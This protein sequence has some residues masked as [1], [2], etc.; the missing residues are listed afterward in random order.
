MVKLPQNL[1]YKRFGRDDVSQFNAN[2]KV[3][4]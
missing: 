2:A 3:T 4:Q 1:F